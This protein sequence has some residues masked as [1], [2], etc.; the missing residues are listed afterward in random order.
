[1]NVYQS[2]LEYLNKKQI[3]I[4]QEAPVKTSTPS[5][6][7]QLPAGVLQ[8]VMTNVGQPRQLPHLQLPRKIQVK[9]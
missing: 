6:A 9:I 7:L 8:Y 3:P 2:I 5:I 4:K 1:M